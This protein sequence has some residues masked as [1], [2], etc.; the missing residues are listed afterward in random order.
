V[1][2][3]DGRQSLE[4]PSRLNH[5]GRIETFTEPGVNRRENLSCLSVVT[6]FN[7]EPSEL[8]RRPQLR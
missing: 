5:I 2:I 6:A 1:T 7:E 3:S 8:Q 4:Q